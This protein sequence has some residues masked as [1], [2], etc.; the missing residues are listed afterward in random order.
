MTHEQRAL[1]AEQRSAAVRV[2]AHL[3]HELLE[4]ALDGERP[5]LRERR[6]QHDAL[7]RFEQRLRGALDGFEAHVAREAVRDDDVEIGR[8]DVRPLRVAREVRQLLLQQGVGLLGELRALR[9][10]L[11]DV[12]QRRAR[13]LDADDALGVDGGHLAELHEVLGL[14]VGV[15]ADVAHD[16]GAH[17]RRDD[18]GERG[19][20]DALDAAH[21]ERA[22]RKAG[23]GGA[24]GEEAL[25]GTLLHETAA[26]HDGRVLLLAHRVRGVLRHA[27]DLG[28]HLRRAALVRRREGLHDVGRAA[29]DNRE[30]LVGGKRLGNAFE[31]HAGSVV[32]SHGINGDGDLIVRHFETSLLALKS[33]RGFEVPD[34]APPRGCD[35]E[36]VPLG[37]R[38]SVREGKR[39]RGKIRCIKASQ[40]RAVPPFVERRNA[41][42]ASRRITRGA[43]CAGRL[44]NAR[45]QYARAWAVR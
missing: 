20:G 24:G 9:V 5:Q 28:A 16:D 31:H 17:G 25:R 34:I 22:R 6:G 3:R 35:A 4:P 40:C 7:E 38:T 27:D 26:H 37:K 19:S 44:V 21:D 10:L 29:Q 12:E 15:R 39:T 33:A 41:R 2:G 36:L 13:V 45:Q 8:Q 30:A 23:A 1:H 43:R 42:K 14:A 11:A 18:G 32:A